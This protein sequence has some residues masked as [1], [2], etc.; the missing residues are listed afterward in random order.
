MSGKNLSVWISHSQNCLSYTA[1]VPTGFMHV[2]RHKNLLFY[3]SCETIPCLIYFC[4][5]ELP[6]HSSLLHDTLQ[7]SSFSSRSATDVHTVAD[8]HLAFFFFTATLTLSPTVLAAFAW[9]CSVFLRISI[10]PAPA[11]CPALSC[12]SF[13]FGG[14]RVEMVMHAVQNRERG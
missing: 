5:A 8:H 11:S 14:A 9:L 3:L 13:F 7:S 12:G 4:Q 10:L 1:L 2:V 6:S